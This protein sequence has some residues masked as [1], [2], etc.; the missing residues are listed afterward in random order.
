MPTI[1]PPATDPL[2]GPGPDMLRFLTAWLGVWPSTGRFRVAPSARRITPGWDDRVHPLLGVAADERFGH[3]VALSVPPLSFGRVRKLVGAHATPSAIDRQALGALLPAALGIPERRFIEA[4][5]RWTTRPT[6]L[7]DI[8]T[9][10]RSD[11]PGLP[12]WLRPFNGPVLVATDR[13]GRYT[14]GVG[15]KQHNRFGHELAVHTDPDSRGRGLARALVAQAARHVLAKG[16]IAIYIHDLD[17]TG[18]ARVAEAAGF[19]DHGWRWL[20]LA[21]H[22]RTAPL[23]A[24]ASRRRR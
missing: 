22:P 5:L 11:D 12:S 24:P 21:E 4:T 1:A 10:Q 15:I 17:N 19:P 13:S 2:L 3:A 20:G 6:P 14:A 23:Q 9:W 16:A 8:G 18:S 7:P